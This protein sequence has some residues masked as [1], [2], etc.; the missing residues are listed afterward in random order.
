MA[1]LIAELKSTISTQTKAI[2]ALKTGQE[3]L[4]QEQ[5]TLVAQNETLRGEIR[6]LKEQINALHHAQPTH[7]NK[8]TRKQGEHPEDNHSSSP[9]RTQY[10]I[11]TEALKKDTTTREIQVAGV[12][13][14]KMGYLVRFRNKEAKERRCFN[15]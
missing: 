8:H 6:F 9:I 12:G 15:C 14:T 11:I 5:R 2:E 7:A 4:K 10:R 13:T 1:W 3:E